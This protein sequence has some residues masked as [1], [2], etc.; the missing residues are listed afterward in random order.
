M[1]ELGECLGF[2]ALIARD[3]DGDEALEGALSSEVDVSEAPGAEPNEEIE[4]ADLFSD[5]YLGG[6]ILVHQESGLVESVAIDAEERL[7]LLHDIR[8]AIAVFEGGGSFSGAASGVVFFEDQIGDGNFVEDG[9][10]FEIVF[11]ETAEAE[12]VALFEIDFGEF[13][14]NGG[15]EGRGGLGDSGN[16][17]GG[18]SGFPE[19]E[20]ILDDFRQIV[21]IAG[22]LESCGHE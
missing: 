15:A 5:L 6:I 1:V 2:V 17:I 13:E 19:S 20:V 21:P 9:E 12:T 8:E 7:D 10:I 16:E 14:G 3:F 4:I 22:R 18:R 11:D